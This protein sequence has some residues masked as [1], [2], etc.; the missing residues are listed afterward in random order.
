MS[1]WAFQ[2]KLDPKWAN[3]AYSKIGD[4]SAVGCF[5]PNGYDLYDMV[6]NVLEWTRSLYRPCPYQPKDG[7]EESLKSG[8]RVLRGG[9]FDDNSSYARCSV[10]PNNNP[11]PFARH[12]HYGL[13]VAVTPTFSER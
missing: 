2:E 6:G 8:T 13:R 10:R 7:R 12:S 5:P 4:T 1:L 11:I 9:A 3:Y